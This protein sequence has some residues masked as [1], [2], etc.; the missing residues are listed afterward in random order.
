MHPSVQGVHAVRFIRTPRADE[1]QTH[2]KVPVTCRRKEVVADDLLETG[3]HVIL[4]QNGTFLYRYLKSSVPPAHIKV[5][6]GR[7]M[8]AKTP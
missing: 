3:A 6:N 4:V 1:R 5:A 7:I 2:L 8:G